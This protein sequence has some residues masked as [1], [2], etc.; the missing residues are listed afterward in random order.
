M[1]ASYL[2]GTTIDDLSRQ[3]YLH[4][5][6]VIHHLGV[7][8][9]RRRKSVRK[10]T[11]RLLDEAIDHY[12]EGIVLAQVAQEFKFHPRTLHREFVKAV[13]KIRIRW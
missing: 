12:E 8:G 7:S 11:D 6:T 10:M 9:V 2:A 5:T 3:F 4:R 13:V 1:V